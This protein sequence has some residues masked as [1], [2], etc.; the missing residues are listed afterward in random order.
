[1]D[2][3]EDN[4]TPVD[5]LPQE[6][7]AQIL[8]RRQ[9]LASSSNA[10]RTML[11]ESATLLLDDET[12]YDDLIGKHGGSKPGKKPNIPRNFEAG[13]QQ[14]YQHYFSESPLYDSRLFRRC[15]TTLWD[16]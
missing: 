9:H 10:R 3:S 2:H 13:Y 5:V 11:L 6:V 15:G 7:L 8:I 12:G 16:E 4:N 1:M 14:L